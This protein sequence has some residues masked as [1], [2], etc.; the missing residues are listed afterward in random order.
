MVYLDDANGQFMRGGHQMRFNKVKSHLSDD[1]V[2]IFG[3]GYPDPD[4]ILQE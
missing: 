1:T 3:F 4:M 2:M